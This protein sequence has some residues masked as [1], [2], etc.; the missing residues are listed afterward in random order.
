MAWKFIKRIKKEKDKNKDSSD[1]IFFWRLT[2]KWKT[3]LNTWCCTSPIYSMI[4]KMCLVR[5][6]WQVKIW[7][8]D[9][10][11]LYSSYTPLYSSKLWCNVSAFPSYA[12]PCFLDVGVGVHGALSCLFIL[13]LNDLLWNGA[14]SLVCQ[15][16]V[17][18]LCAD[19]LA[20]TLEAFLSRNRY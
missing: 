20:L 13:L 7:S 5:F 16:K 6:D 15:I 19:S 2:R 8:K 17:D 3:Y 10:V 9:K 18:S 12:C 4:W 11:F 1:T 14:S